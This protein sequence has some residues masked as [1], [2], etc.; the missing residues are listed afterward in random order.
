[1]ISNKSTFLKFQCEFDEFLA[2]LFIVEVNF[3]S[4][5]PVTLCLY[6]MKIILPG[7]LIMSTYTLKDAI[8]H[9]NNSCVLEKQKASHLTG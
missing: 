4:K 8:T 7:F 1:M 5:V 3:K 6:L 2:L 9:V